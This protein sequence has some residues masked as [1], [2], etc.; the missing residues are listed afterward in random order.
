LVR[1]HLSVGGRRR[2]ET[3]RN[4]DAEARQLPDHFADGGVLAPDGLDVVHR[5]AFEGQ[6]EFSHWR[7][8]ELESGARETDGR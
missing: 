2:C 7:I 4:F 8:L 5:Q 1:E 6:Y 3:A